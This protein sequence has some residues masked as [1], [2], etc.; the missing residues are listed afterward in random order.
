MIETIQA[1]LTEKTQLTKNVFIFNFTFVYPQTIAFQAGQYLIL[2][3]PVENKTVKRL[4]SVLSPP[5]K[6]DGFALLIQLVNGGIG[7]NY[8]SSLKLGDTALFHGPAGLFVF[9]ESRL[10]KTLLVT[11]TGIAP[12]WSI[13]N[14]HL[15]TATNEQ[16]RLYWGLPQF[17]DVY[18]FDKMIR[19][20]QNYPNFSFK[21]CL[22][23]ETNLN[24]IPVEN[25]RFFN[26]GR[27]DYGSEKMSNGDFYL[28]GS[29]DV[30]QA[31]KELVLSLGANH[32]HIYFEKF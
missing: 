29:R 16:W 11:G 10:S 28:C 27:I 20:A 13:I 7:S 4:Y 32:N 8:L 19:L 9:R 22:S 31:L 18:F 24:M 15:P 14:T 1:K 3:V 23:R 26:L 17:T 30:V 12:V 5:G 25:R 6:K 21:I 2:D